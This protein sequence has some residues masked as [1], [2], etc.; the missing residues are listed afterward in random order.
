MAKLILKEVGYRNF[1]ST[2]NSPTIIKI[3]EHKTTLLC[4]NKGSGKT[5]LNDAITFTWFNKALRKINKAQLVN[6]INN[7]NTETYTIFS[8]GENEYK[9]TRGIKPNKLE[10][11]VN[12]V[13]IDLA[14]GKEPQDWLEELLGFTFKTMKHVILLGNASFTPFMQMDA[15]ERRELVED[16]RDLDV[17]SAMAKLAKTDLD[18]LNKLFINV[19]S[20]H[21]VS[22]N[23][24][25]MLTQF[26][27]ESEKDTTERKSSIL[28]D[29]KQ[30]EEII[31]LKRSERAL[32]VDE[33]KTLSG[34]FIIV[35]ASFGM[36][37]A[38]LK[39]DRDTAVAKKKRLEASIDDFSKLTICPTCKQEVG[40]DHKHG[41]QEKV[42]DSIQKLSIGIV[43]IQK[44]IDDK[45]IAYDNFVNTNAEINKKLDVLRNSIKEIDNDIK[46][47]KTFIEKYEL[48]LNDIDKSGENIDTRKEELRESRL[49]NITQFGEI[50]T[51][52]ENISIIQECQKHLKDD[53]IKSS[54]IDAFIPIFNSLVNKYL[55][56]M[57]FF[58]RFELDKEFNE[59]IKSRHR[60]V[61]SYYSFSEGEKQTI[62]IALLF[63]WRELTMLSG[64]ALTNVIVL[65]EVFD[66]SL[67]ADTTGL[68]IDILSNMGEDTNI[69]VI[70]HKPVDAFDGFDRI[71]TFEKQKNFSI[72][73][74]IE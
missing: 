33:G 48:M 28:E 57:D 55:G 73:K 61:F 11:L 58:V 69:I 71:I 27:N 72:M 50:Q 26:I 1:L 60:D 62:D 59:T 47:A 29:I 51:L 13:E 16:L 8:I 44:D 70:S 34:T 7:G 43:L 14:S 3:N 25:T 22:S 53:G 36:D 4:G 12:G 21:A 30:Q 54:L 5:T 41:I 74:E 24:V 46:T 64:N 31:S 9:V 15:K 10:I 52:S 20:D 6:S 40:D 45:Q 49:L 63:A 38:G 17:F 18:K 35:P 68:V 56:M 37:L 65:D 32:L 19:N 42:D 23:R 66:S 67:D 39:G 2:G